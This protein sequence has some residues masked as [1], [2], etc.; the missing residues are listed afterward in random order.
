MVGYFL[1]SVKLQGLNSYFCDVFF[2]N[3]KK[4]S[5]KGIRELYFFFTIGLYKSVP[6]FSIIYYYRKIPDPFKIPHDWQAKEEGMVFWPMNVYP[7]IFSYLVFNQS[8]LGSNDLG[9]YKNWKGYSCYMSG[10]L[11]P[12]MYHNLTGSKFCIFK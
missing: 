7:D 3:Y 11:Q 1:V 10:W 8:E 9:D 5:K 4:L 2:F 12:L 6:N